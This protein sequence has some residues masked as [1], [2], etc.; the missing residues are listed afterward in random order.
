MKLKIFGKNVNLNII[1]YM[2]KKEQQNLILMKW[3][4]MQRGN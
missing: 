3:T 4:Y 1:N 2:R